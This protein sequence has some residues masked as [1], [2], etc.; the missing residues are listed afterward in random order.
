MAANGLDTGGTNYRGLFTGSGT[1]YAYGISGPPQL[2]PLGNLIRPFD[3][4]T[5]GNLLGFAFVTNSK[6]PAVVVP[7]Q[8]LG[9]FS[10][11]TIG[12]WR[13]TTISG[14][15]LTPGTNTWKWGSGTQASSVT[16]QIGSLGSAIPEPN[17]FV[18]LTIGAISTGIGHRR[19]RSKR[20]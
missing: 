16:I 8:V 5:A 13:N 9:N 15:G 18:F 14:L 1:Y 11:S 2:S 19:T 6:I 4:R 10:S 17:S 12:T 20:P 3:S 7:T